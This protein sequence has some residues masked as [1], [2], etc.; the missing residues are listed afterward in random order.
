MVTTIARL[1]SPVETLVALSVPARSPP[2]N[3]A[4][5]VP[6]GALNVTDCPATTSLK[7]CIAPP[8]TCNLPSIPLSAAPSVDMF[9]AVSAF[10][11]RY[12]ER[13]GAALCGRGELQLHRCSGRPTR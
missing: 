4:L 5:M 7:V 2:E 1:P 10:A 12:L 6:A 11:A 9:S 3:I 8:S 13:C